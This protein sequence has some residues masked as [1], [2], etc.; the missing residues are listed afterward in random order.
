MLAESLVQ[1]M[2][3]CLIKEMQLVSPITLFQDLFLRVLSH[4]VMPLQSDLRMVVY[5]E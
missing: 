5:K 3:L 4:Y 2:C 1:R